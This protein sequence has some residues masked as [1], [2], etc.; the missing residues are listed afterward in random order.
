MA[1]TYAD[2]CMAAIKVE[3]FLTFVVP[4][5]AALALYNIYIEKR[6]YVV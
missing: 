3:V 4:Y 2:Y 5:L 1:M 6:I